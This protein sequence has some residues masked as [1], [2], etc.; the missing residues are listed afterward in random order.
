MKKVEFKNEKYSMLLGRQNM[1]RKAS[2]R[3]ALIRMLHGNLL[4]DDSLEMPILV[5]FCTSPESCITFIIK[6][7]EYSEK[8]SYFISGTW[9]RGYR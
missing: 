4:L 9:I 6:I 5:L 7:N 3:N 8:K 2:E 1:P